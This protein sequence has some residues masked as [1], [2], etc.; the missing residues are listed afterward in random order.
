MMKWLKV[1]ALFFVLHAAAW[2][3][4]HWYLNQNRE[5]VL[6]VVDTSYAMKPNFPSMTE[7]IEAYDKGSRYRTVMVGTDKAELGVLSELKSYSVIFRTAFGKMSEESLNRYRSHPANQKI[8]LSDG[9]VNPQ[10][11]TLVTFEE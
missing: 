1:F 5:T 10:G 8:L 4:A 9:S 3:G 6:I 2:A 11:W 7:W